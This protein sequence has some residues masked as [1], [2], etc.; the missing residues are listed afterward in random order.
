MDL[1]W[2]PWKSM[3]FDHKVDLNHQPAQTMKP[4]NQ[5]IIKWAIFWMKSWTKFMDYPLLKIHRKSVK[6]HNKFIENQWKLNE[7]L[8]QNDPFLNEIL[9][10]FKPNSSSILPKIQPILIQILGWD[11]IWNNGFGLRGHFQV[12]TSIIKFKMLGG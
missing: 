2:D 6:S 1:G 10:K 8:A 9:T 4:H 7:I 11:T 3:K 5:F 12:I